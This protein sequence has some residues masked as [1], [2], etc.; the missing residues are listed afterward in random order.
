VRE[1]GREHSPLVVVH[2]LIAVNGVRAFVDCELRVGNEPPPPLKRKRRTKE[3][4]TDEWSALTRRQSSKISEPL[5]RYHHLIKSQ[6]A[7]D[8]RVSLQ[9]RSTHIEVM[10]SCR[11]EKIRTNPARKARGKAHSD[12][13]GSRR[14]QYS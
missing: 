6:S 2:E 8:P 1:G 10:F 9:G 7:V 13:C 4:R 3:G 5:L 12:Q 14:G 11:G